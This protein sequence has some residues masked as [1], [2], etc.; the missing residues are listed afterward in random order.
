VS[1]VA[2]PRDA[3]AVLAAEQRERVYRP[4]GGLSPVLLVD[5]WIEGVWGARPQWRGGWR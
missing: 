1:V 3:E 2:A 5:G 4:Q